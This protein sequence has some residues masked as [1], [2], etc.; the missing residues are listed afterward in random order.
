MATGRRCRGLILAVSAALALAAGASLPAAAAPGSAQDPEAVARQREELR[1]RL[2]SLRKQIAE[3]EA[4]RDEAADALREFDEAISDIN[5]RLADLA[6]Q[7]KTVQA[8]LADIQARQKATQAEVVERQ[9][10]IARLL[11]QD[12]LGNG[13]SPL[14]ALLSGDNP[15]QAARD[16][17][18]VGYVSAAQARLIA[19]LRT[20]QAQLAELESAARERETAL[21]ALVREQAAQRETLVQQAKARKKLVADLSARL[22]AQRKEAG[23]LER[24]EQRLS[25]VI[26][27]LTRMLAERERRRKAAEKAQKAAEE[28]AERLA[29]QREKSAARPSG[30][31]ETHP[32]APTLRN[33][34]SPEDGFTGRFARLRGKL[35]LP[36]PGDIAGRFGARR[37]DAGASW[38]GLF[39]R[40]GNGSEVKAVAPGRVV[41]AEWLRGFGNLIIL[42]HGDQYL[43]IYGNNEALLKQPGDVVDSGETIAHVGTSGGN[44]EPGLYF[45]LRHQ[46]QPFDPLKWA[47]LK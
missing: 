15:N 6:R 5:R 27:E 24:N 26:G 46:G 42:D 30:A 13:Q 14:K 34:S 18:Y 2:S 29:A 8:E 9:N 3:G 32:P 12:Y 1:E 43:S 41:Y 37:G 16:A 38:K 10:Q 17:A 21:A 20:L 4:G 45:E 23:G 31:T 25:Q 35:R 39:I 7:Q 33:E 36:V 47:A 22:S 44:A 19:Q 40:A 28:R 11:H